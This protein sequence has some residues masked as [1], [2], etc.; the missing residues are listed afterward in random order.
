M[1]NIIPTI[2]SCSDLF[3]GS[4]HLAPTRYLDLYIPNTTQHALMWIWL[5]PE[6]LNLN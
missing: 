6:L 4:V 1:E 2:T 3:L 5:G